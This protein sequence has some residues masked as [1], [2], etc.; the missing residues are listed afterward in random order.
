MQTVSLESLIGN[1]IDGQEVLLQTLGVTE[2]GPR[3]AQ[4][5]ACAVVRRISDLRQLRAVLS[6]AHGEMALLLSGY[7][8]A[9]PGSR[10][11][12]SEV[13]GLLGQGV[14]TRILFNSAVRE[15]DD[16]RGWIRAAAL[17]AEVRWITEEFT[18]MI[19]I[20]GRVALILDGSAC[21]TA[22]LISE[23][24]IVTFLT[25]VFGTMWSTAQ[26]AALAAAEFL[27]RRV[28]ASTRESIIDMLVSGKPDKT[29][30]KRL[31]ISL[32]SVQAHIATLR[33]ELGANTRTQLGYQLARG[34][35]AAVD[36][37]S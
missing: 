3:A 6:T 9:A 16:C 37:D 31:G 10:A 19:V 21:S 2:A 15:V 12:L 1:L 7:A 36:P 27:P 26:N 18:P 34:R 30:A 13:A 5:R 20:D 23:P 14:A 25:R 29:I 17:G 11:L 35:R 33:T 4:P 8:D 32:R 28:P 24:T 22:L